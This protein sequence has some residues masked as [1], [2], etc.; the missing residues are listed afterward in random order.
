MLLKDTQIPL[1]KEILAGFYHRISTDLEPRHEFCNPQWC[2]YLISKQK[3]ELYIH[4]PALETSI[5]EHILPIYEALNN[6]DVLRRCLGAN[7]QN[8]NE[9]YNNLICKICPKSS[10]ASK[11]VVEIASWVAASAFN[12]G[13]TTYLVIMDLMG[14]KIGEVA[15]A[16]AKEID[17]IRIKKANKMNTECS[18]EA[19]IKKKKALEESLR[20]LA[21]TEE[22][23]YSPAMAD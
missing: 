1:K 3:N 14:I 10:F 19:R 18:K 21:G 7:T 2:T 5:R 16:W 9:S 22:V 20:L 6:D 15:T 4:E 13:A 17:W 11:E 23:Q 8:N 12:E